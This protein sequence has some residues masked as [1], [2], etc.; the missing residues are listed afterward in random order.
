MRHS[1]ALDALR[2]CLR[3]GFRDAGQGDQAR[4][5]KLR[6]E[7][8]ID[9]IAISQLVPLLDHLTPVESRALF[10]LLFEPV[11]VARTLEAMPRPALTTLLARMDERVLA[12][13]LVGLSGPSLARVMALLAPERRTPLRRRMQAEGDAFA[14]RVR[15]VSSV[16][17]PHAGAFPGQARVD[18]VLPAVASI[19]QG[20]CVWVLGPQGEPIGQVS[21]AG[22]QAATPDARLEDL[23]ATGV[24]TVSSCTPL[25]VALAALTGA[26]EQRELPVVDG[27]GRLLGVVGA[28]RLRAVLCAEEATSNEV[29]VGPSWRRL[30]GWFA[31]SS[32]GVACL[33][34]G[35]F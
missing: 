8:L 9:S 16:L 13:S 25:H 27:Q 33:Y 12:S 3:H 28:A 1:I 34:L 29:A 24:R 26:P 35:L 31:G 14:A 6:A 7:K 20:A 17:E 22:L 10:G 11:R 4:A 32:A 19:S 21:K 15:P 23:M 30:M 5:D 2:H 18:A